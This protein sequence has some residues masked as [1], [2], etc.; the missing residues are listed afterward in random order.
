[1]KKDEIIELL[2]EQLKKAEERE[3]KLNAR[4]NELVAEVSSLKEAL[5]GKTYSFS[6]QQRIYSGLKS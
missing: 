6:K 5:L 1:M 4:I 3:H 2:K